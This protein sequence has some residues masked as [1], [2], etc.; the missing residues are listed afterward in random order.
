MEKEDLDSLHDFL[1]K[2]L[3]SHPDVRIRTK[4]I[5]QEASNEPAD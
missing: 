1:G 2:I 5:K 4:Q 3:D